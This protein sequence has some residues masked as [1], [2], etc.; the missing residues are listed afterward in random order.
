MINTSFIEN[1]QVNIKANNPYIF[2]MDM[3]RLANDLDGTFNHKQ[4]NQFILI[5]LPLP[6]G[7]S[8]TLKLVRNNVMHPGLA[9]KFPEIKTF[10]AVDVN[11]KRIKAKL[12]ITPHGFHAMIFRDGNPTVFID[13]YLRNNNKYY[14]SYAKDDFITDKTMQCSFSG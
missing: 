13:P 12:D 4:I 7:G 14:I 2:S 11:D 8:S 6:D 5:T 1:E 10:D 3:E 9:I